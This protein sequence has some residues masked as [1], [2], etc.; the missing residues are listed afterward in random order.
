MLQKLVVSGLAFL[1]GCWMLSSVSSS[2][3]SGAGSGGE[4]GS[5]SPSATASY[6]SGA[7]SGGGV[8]SGSTSSSSRKMRCEVYQGEAQ[9]TMEEDQ[10][11]RQ[12]KSVCRSEAIKNALVY[13]PSE[14]QFLFGSMTY[15]RSGQRDE[16]VAVEH[17]QVSSYFLLRRLLED[18]IVMTCTGDVPQ[19]TCRIRAEFCELPRER[20]HLPARELALVACPRAPCQYEDF[21]ARETFLE[22]DPLYLRFRLLESGYLAVFIGSYASDSV[23]LIYPLGGDL[24]AP[25]Q[26]SSGEHVL[27]DE[28]EEGSWYYSR[29]AHGILTLFL[30]FSTKPFA[31]PRLKVPLY[32]Y[33]PPG[34]PY[35]E[36]A[37]WLTRELMHTPELR[38]QIVH[39][40]V[41]SAR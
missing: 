32:R 2:S 36:F 22:G 16:Q 29:D 27:F 1:V 6:S 41:R 37:R 19:F 12:A 18:R 17:L 26:L 40:R 30:V 5:S 13:A 38:L 34:M 14:V 31:L 35:E 24:T 8:G 28:P 4:M 23:Y 9:T 39:A 15:L 25:A 3:S 7:Q 21:V 11:L 20:T 33:V 10:T